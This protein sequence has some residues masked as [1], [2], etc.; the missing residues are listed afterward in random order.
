MTKINKFVQRT[1]YVKKNSPGQTIVVK[2]K[3]INNTSPP[4]MCDQK[5]TNQIR[6]NQK[7][8]YIK[9][10][11]KCLKQLKTFLAQKLVVYTEIGDLDVTS[12]LT[13]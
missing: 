4:K 3:T 12:L 5:S 10:A 8:W 1:V 9:Y 7:K 6:A 13:Q 11:C 2:N